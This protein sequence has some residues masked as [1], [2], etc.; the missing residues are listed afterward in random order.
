MNT[1]NA[2]DATVRD[3]LLEAARWRLTSLLFRRPNGARCVELTS[4]ARE[5][6]EAEL[7][8]AASAAATTTE[9][10]YHAWLGP[11]GPLAPREVS[12]RPIED[13]GRLLAEIAAFHQAFGYHGGTEDPAD[14]IAVAADFMA[15]LFVKEALAAGA[16]GSADAE[17]TRGARE[18][19]AERH[20]RPAARG[21][22]RRMARVVEGVDTAHFA[23]T[24][25]LLVRLSGVAADTSEA[26]AA[27][28]APFLLPGLDDDTIDC[29]AFGDAGGGCK[30][31]CPWDPSHNQSDGATGAD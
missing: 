26:D 13:P 22:A 1:T 3:L 4:L 18:Q 9:G 5:S 24:V 28:D 17:T 11:G 31:A 15:Y 27:A 21:M 29:G 8:D 14:H 10:L 20:V 16:S 7:V 30:A 23:L 2:V 25:G 6:G 12:Y 19:F